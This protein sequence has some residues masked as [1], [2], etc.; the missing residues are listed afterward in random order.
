MNQHQ[1]QCV[2]LTY[3]IKWNDED[4]GGVRIAFMIQIQ[5]DRTILHS[6]YI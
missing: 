5:W 3:F 6:I 4:D 2:R 1:N